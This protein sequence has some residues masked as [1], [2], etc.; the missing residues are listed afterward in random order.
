M[1]SVL[2]DL[3][4]VQLHWILI[5]HIVNY[6]GLHCVPILEPQTLNENIN[7]WGVMLAL[8]LSSLCSVSAPCRTCAMMLPLIGYKLSKCFLSANRLSFD[9]VTTTPSP[10][11]KPEVFFFLLWHR[12]LEL[13]T[14]SFPRFPRCPCQSRSQ[15]LAAFLVPYSSSS[16]TRFFLYPFLSI[17]AGN[18]SST[19]QAVSLRV[20]VQMFV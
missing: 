15:L 12:L 7:V 13:R 17:H 4:W 5:F 3:F 18:F 19:P 16:T 1:R 14:N 11:V 10:C 2:A 9:P 20:T 6:W 8:S